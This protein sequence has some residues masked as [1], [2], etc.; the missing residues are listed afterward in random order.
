MV[1]EVEAWFGR[2]YVEQLAA[3]GQASAE[4]LYGRIATA[5]GAEHVRFYSEKHE[6]GPI[7]RLLAEVDGGSRELLVVRDLRDMACSMLAFGRK[8]V[9]LPEHDGDGD[10]DATADFIVSLA[11]AVAR[12]VA[13]VRERGEAAHVVRYEDLVTAPADTLAWMLSHIGV[14]AEAEVV[15][16]AVDAATA[17]TPEL[18]AHR[19]SPDSAASIGRHADEL[20]PAL[21][22]AADEAFGPALDLFGYERQAWTTAS[23]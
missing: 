1:P 22:Q 8:R 23:R 18:S 5:Q 4:Q 6:P 15:E 21:L 13:Y 9:G 19:T 12:L 2:E 14:S 11:P 3:F 7:A 16:A 20:S 10:E 17:S